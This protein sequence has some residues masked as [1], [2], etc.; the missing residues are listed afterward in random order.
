MGK[1]NILLS[2]NTHFMSKDKLKGDFNN[3]HH[4]FWNNV[5]K[6]LQLLPVTHKYGHA[7]LLQPGS[8]AFKLFLP[9]RKK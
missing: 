4:L 9:F 8:H 1:L 7:A 3:R 6:C 5:A 2:P